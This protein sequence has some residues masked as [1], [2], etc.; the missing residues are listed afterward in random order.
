MKEQELEQQQIWEEI[1]EGWTG[2]RHWPLK[3]A[4]NLAVE[5]KLGRILDIGCGNGRNIIPFAKAG[6]EC[7][8]VDFSMRM[9]ELAKG[10]FKKA[11]LKAEFKVAHAI[12]LP[13][14][15]EEF[16]YCLSI[17]MLHHI[18]GEEERKKAL[19]EMR[20]V[21]KPGGKALLMVWNKFSPAH[22]RLAFMPK[23]AHIP[24]PR[25]GQVYQRYYYLFDY[26]ELKGSVEKSEFR[27]LKSGGFFDE[28]ITFIVEKV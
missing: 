6:F 10:S 13:Y 7:H 25:K 28:N 4:E 18:K 17:A 12:K 3:E 24:W 22:W 16:D 2:W 1:A 9:T 26:W 11:G 27:I 15:S 5:W 23:E 14:A 21:L 8:G 19:A 20:R